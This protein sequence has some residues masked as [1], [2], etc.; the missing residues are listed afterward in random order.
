M[1]LSFFP[2]W[3]VFLMRG[4]QCRLGQSWRLCN[5]IRSERSHQKIDYSEGDEI[6][7]LCQLLPPGAFVLSLISYHTALRHTYYAHFASYR[8]CLVHIGCLVNFS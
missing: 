4:A 2:P 5:H 1:L 6:C 8:L 7:Q 3:Q